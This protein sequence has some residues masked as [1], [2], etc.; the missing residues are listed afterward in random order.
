MGWYIKRPVKVE[1]MQWTGENL[2]EIWEWS[3]PEYLPYDETTQKLT[4]N[5]LEGPIYASLGDFII[6][7]T[8][9]ELYPCKPDAFEAVYEP[10]ADEGSCP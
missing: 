2:F 6:R 8:Q 10:I 1:A 4:I 9:A 3:F 7:G 5:T